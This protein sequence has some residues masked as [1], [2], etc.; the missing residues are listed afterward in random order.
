MKKTASI[1]IVLTLLI[2]Q[3]SAQILDKIQLKGGAM[4]EFVTFQQASDSTY[5]TLSSPQPVPYVNLYIGGYYAIAHK[6]DIISIG[7]DAGLQGGL[8]IRRTGFAYQIQIPA[9]LMGRI[10]AG[11]TTYNQQKVGLGVGIGLQN[12]YLKDIFEVTNADYR[13][14]KTALF[15]PSAVVDVVIGGQRNLIGRL[16]LPLLPAK[17]QFETL[18]NGYYKM[19]NFGFGLLYRF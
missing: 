2:G 18:N 1:F 17:K 10:G 7:V 9:Y 5:T 15:I 14:V 4:Y 13:T 6:N 16:H 3:M 12:T 11:A 8:Y 19:S